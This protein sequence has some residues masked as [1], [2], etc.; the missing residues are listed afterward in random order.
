MSST[1]AEIHAAAL[2]RLRERAPEVADAL[3]LGPAQLRDTAAGVLSCSDFVL[4]AIVREPSICQS[5]LA[6]AHTQLSGEPLDPRPSAVL[7]GD[8]MVEESVFMAALRH[9]RRA[10]FTRIAWRDLAG[11]ADLNGTLADLSRAADLCVRWAHDFALATLKKR[12]G[13]PLSEAGGVQELI[14]VAMGKLGGEELNFSSDIDLVLL[15]PEAGE[16]DGPRSLSNQEFFTR[17]AQA[18]VR[19]LEQPT[20]DGFVFRVDLRLRPFG[21]S[22]PVVASAAALEDYLQLHGRDWERYAWVKARAITNLAAY[23]TLLRE[24]IQPFVYRRY[25]DFGVFESLREMKALIG[26]EV[27]RRDLAENIKLGAGGIR[28]IEFI[29]QSFQLLRGGQDR[30]LQ[31][32]SLRRVLPLLAGAKLLAATDVAEL[33]NAYEFLR[34]VENRLQMRAEQQTHLL[35]NDESQR[36]RLALSMGFENWQLLSTRLEQVRA[37]VMRQFRAVMFG[38]SSHQAAAGGG[39]VARALHDPLPMEEG[40]GALLDARLSALGLPDPA[41]AQLLR[42]LYERRTS[43]TLG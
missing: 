22:G 10:E 20:E 35:P 3:A 36:Q 30:R 14:V 27:E 28:E 33:D 37:A 42:G 12:Y 5:L 4:D 18:L 6:R 38:V 40:A 9:W 43:V 15:Y 8:S 21:D 41:A 34:R 13:R 1:T 32:R 25:L 16:T 11:W 19:L 7:A 26:R 24:T 29:V 2:Q 23:E 39:E 31:L 17:V